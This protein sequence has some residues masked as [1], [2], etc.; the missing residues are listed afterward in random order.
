MEPSGP[1]YFR[2]FLDEKSTICRLLF[3]T[4]PTVHTDWSAAEWRRGHHSIPGMGGDQVGQFAN[5]DHAM[6]R[7]SRMQFD[8]KRKMAFSRDLQLR[9]CCD[10][11]KPGQG[12]CVF[13]TDLGVKRGS[14]R[15]QQYSATCPQGTK[16]VDLFETWQTQLREIQ[17][18]FSVKNGN[19]QPSFL[20]IR[21]VMLNHFN[22]AIFKNK[23]SSF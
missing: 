10:G 5:A 14:R 1:L 2:N 4:R 9:M 22:S 15:W 7:E 11:D 19:S 23:S 18:K 3:A 6:E 8:W 21:D 17:T 20:L 12:Q 13:H 16:K